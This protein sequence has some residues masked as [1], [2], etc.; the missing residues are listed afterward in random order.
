MTGAVSF[1]A[2]G[3]LVIGT[4]APTSGLASGNGA[5][6]VSASNLTVAVGAL[7]TSGVG[8]TLSG[9][10]AIDIPGGSSD[11]V[12]AFNPATSTFYM[13]SSNTAGGTRRL[14]STVRP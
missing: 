5:V 3:D 11:T 4:V 7:V 1:I 12:G 10:Q 6:T 2:G 13:A 9:N 14:P 8:V